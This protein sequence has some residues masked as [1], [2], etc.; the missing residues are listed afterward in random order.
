[1]EDILHRAKPYVDMHSLSDNGLVDY[2]VV[3][4]FFLLFDFDDFIN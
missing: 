4:L 3:V 1:M 2:Y